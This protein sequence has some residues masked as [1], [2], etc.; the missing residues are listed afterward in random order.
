[1]KTIIV[2]CLYNRIKG[3]QYLLKNIILWMLSDYNCRQGAFNIMRNKINK[4]TWLR[5][6]TNMDR[7]F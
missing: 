4:N 3:S 1:M 2:S 6:L 5:D 7:L